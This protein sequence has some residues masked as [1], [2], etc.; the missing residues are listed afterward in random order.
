MDFY[1]KTNT[2]YIKKLGP[3]LIV[4]KCEDLGK[5]LLLSPFQVVDASSNVVIEKQTLI[6]EI[7]TLEGLIEGKKRV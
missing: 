1:Q 5:L 3:L 2:P 4:F 7:R 6:L